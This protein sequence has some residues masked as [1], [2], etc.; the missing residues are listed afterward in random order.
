METPD[1]VLI[2][3]S[4]LAAMLAGVKPPTVLDVR[5]NLSGPPASA[6]YE[7]GHIPGA[8]WVDLETDLAAPPGEGGRHPLP[9]AEVFEAAMRRAGVSGDRPVVVY[10]AK[11]SSMGAARGWWCLRYFGHSRVRVLDGGLAAWR[12]G[13][14][15]V[16]TGPGATPP[17][18]DFTA[19]PGAM[20]TLTPAEVVRL[21]ER[22]GALIDARAA[23]RYRGEVE[24]IDPVAG[25][26]PGAR[27]LP[28]DQLLRS[29]GR[30]LDPAAL[31]ERFR[32]VGAGG[33]IVVGAYCGSG[34]VAAHT[35]LAAAHA[36]FDAWLYVGSWSDWV[37]DSTRPV[38]KGEERASP[39]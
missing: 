14:Y 25:H 10:D 8:V 1:R 22:G 34:V 16:D 5:W 38:A 2:T 37:S 15:R 26:I 13:A 18:G 23:E 4:E 20:H 7:A 39:S 32:R 27:N 28:S 36:G 19:R 21:V 9:S 33:H 31:R 6:E 29:D 12:A 24:P 17:A 11:S 35:V 30:F 3:A